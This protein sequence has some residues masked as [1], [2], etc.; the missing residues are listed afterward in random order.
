MA[1][2]YAFGAVLVRPAEER[3]RLLL[4]L[5]AALT[6][7]FVVFRAVNRYGDPRPWTPQRSPLFTLF[8]FI[9][10]SKYPPSLDYLLMTLGPAIALLGAIDKRLAAG[11]TPRW[12]RPL[13]TFGRVPFFFYVLHVPLLHGL[14]VVLGAAVMGAAGASAIAHKITLP[15][16]EAA[17]FGFPLPVVY[18]AWLLVVAALYPACRWFADVKARHRAAWLSYL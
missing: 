16:A 9:A 5:G 8:S 2:G 13:V 1:L 4:R 7:A 18:A 17:R 12:A 14:A 10:C 15:D 6:L 11:E 3:R